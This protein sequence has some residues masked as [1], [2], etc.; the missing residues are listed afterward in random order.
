GGKQGLRYEWSIDQ[1]AWG[2]PYHEGEI[3]GSSALL[4]FTP[5]A[6]GYYVLRLRVTNTATGE[7]TADTTTVMTALRPH[8][9][10]QVDKRVIAQIR[11]LRDAQD[12][13]WERFYRRLK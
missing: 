12:P 6:P 8:P 11:Q 5:K 10:L 2:S 1:P 4:S 9:R 7:S 3:L 13:L